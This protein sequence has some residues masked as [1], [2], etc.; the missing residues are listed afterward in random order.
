LDRASSGK[1]APSNFL[2]D[3]AWTSAI[4]SF[5]PKMSAAPSASCLTSTGNRCSPWAV[6]NVSAMRTSR[7]A[8]RCGVHTSG[9]TTTS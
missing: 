4:G 3:A 6:L 7:V 5:Q 2:I 1:S 8:A 9:F